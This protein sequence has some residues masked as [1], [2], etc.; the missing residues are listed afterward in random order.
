MWFCRCDPV[1]IWLMSQ[2]VFSEILP[3]PHKLSLLQSQIHI[4]DQLP[5]LSH[6]DTVN[7][8]CYFKLITVAGT[9]YPFSNV[10]DKYHKLKNISYEIRIY[11]FLLWGQLS[12][13][14]GCPGRLWSLHPWTYPK[15]SG[16][17]PGQ[18]LAGDP[19]WAEGLAQVTPRGA[20][21]PQT[22]CDSVK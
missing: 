10:Q 15:P 16:H 12:T 21:Q 22:L 1:V 4:K 8:K 2:K 13:S 14:M 19:T 17:S 18:T 3:L 5:V 6:K 11:F 20:F 9:W 7:S